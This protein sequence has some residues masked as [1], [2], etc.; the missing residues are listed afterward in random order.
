MRNNSLSRSFS[1]AHRHSLSLSTSQSKPILRKRSSH[2]VNVSRLSSAATL[3]TSVLAGLRQRVK[4]TQSDLSPVQAAELISRYLLPMFEGER[5]TRLHPMPGTV[6]GELKLSASLG[7]E[8]MELREELRMTRGKLKEAEQG[9][10]AAVSDLKGYQE[11]VVVME[12]HLRWVRHKASEDLGKLQT[13]V[14]TEEGLRQELRKLMESYEDLEEANK[15]CHAQLQEQAATIDKLRNRAIEQEHI[16]SLLIM[17]NDI[18]GERLKG[19]YFAIEKVTDS[20]VFEEVI[21]SEIRNM[22][23]NMKDLMEYAEKIRQNLCE[24]LF[25]T[26]VLKSDNHELV[27]ERNEMK[28]ERDKLAKIA[29]DKITELQINLQKT[30]DEREKLRLRVEESEKKFKDLSDEYEKLRHKM[31]QYRQRR[32]QFG[33]EEE[34][35]CRHCQ[36]VYLESENYNWSCRRHP[37]EYSGEIYWCCGKRSRDALGCKTSKHESKEDEEDK[38]TKDSSGQT[39]LICPVFLTQSC[40]KF[41]H[42]AIDC[43]R[44]PNLRSQHDVFEEVTRVSSMNQTKK[45]EDEQVLRQQALEILIDR[46][47]ESLFNLIDAESISDDDSESVIL[48]GSEE[49]QSDDFAEIRKIKEKLATRQKEER[50]EELE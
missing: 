47:T 48:E 45:K 7:K 11:K 12:S 22:A 14:L 46:N 39:A 35:V 13:A 9:E 4:I 38:L 20:F 44:D 21:N 8:L 28:A 16:N 19:L 40:K 29:K 25:A 34:K 5:D 18:I 24:N 1:S 27:L 30:E 42:F 3:T 32:K 15:A 6:Y 26:D 50:T 31:K 49:K 2:P 17:E 43:P 41:G 23:M 10:N 36:R 37:N 33:E